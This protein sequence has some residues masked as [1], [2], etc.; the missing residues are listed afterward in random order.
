[1]LKA[2]FQGVIGFLSVGLLALPGCN[3]EPAANA[4][5]PMPVVQMF[6]LDTPVE[7]IAADGRGK[8]VLDRDLPGLMGSS[9]YVLFDDMSLSQIATLSSGQLTETKLELV[10]ADLSEIS[11]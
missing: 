6:S 2:S 4:A 7:K 3:Q 11:R 5:R 1:M 8:A 10:A 9:S